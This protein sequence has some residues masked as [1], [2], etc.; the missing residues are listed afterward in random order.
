[1][2][3]D[4]KIYVGEEGAKALYKRL[5]A[6]IGKITIYQKVTTTTPQ[7]VPVVE[8]PNTRTI[9]LV[10]DNSVVGDD[11]YK[12]WIWNSVDL[13]EC[14]GTTSI[15]ENAWKQ[16]SEDNAIQVMGD[17]RFVAVEGMSS[18]KKSDFS[19]G[20]TVESGDLVINNGN[21][22]VSGNIS[23]SNIPA[24][25]VGDG[26]YTLTCDVTDGVATYRWVPVGLA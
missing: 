1:M 17:G 9:Y 4:T 12:E 21:L 24:A 14:I 19:G 15:P 5:K 10:K 3:N 16:W 26:S 7:G 23:A 6:Q 25:P 20:V 22:S 8:G 2:A 13:W 11:K 18:W